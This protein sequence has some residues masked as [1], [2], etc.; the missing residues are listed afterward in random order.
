[1]SPKRLHVQ[2]QSAAAYHA[3]DA[4][5]TQTCPP[6]QAMLPIPRLCRSWCRRAARPRASA[7]TP[8]SA[9][10]AWAHAAP[11]SAGISQLAARAG[12]L[13]LP[14]AVR[15]M[16]APANRHRTADSPSLCP[17]PVQ[18]PRTAAPP[19]AC[20]APASG[21]RLARPPP[22][23]R[24]SRRPLPRLPSIRWRC[25]A[26]ALWATASAQTPPSAAPCGERLNDDSAVFFV[27]AA[28]WRPQGPVSSR[29]LLRRAG[30]LASW[31]HCLAQGSVGSGLLLRHCWSTCPMGPLFPKPTS[32]V[33]C[34]PLC[35]GFCGTGYAWC[36]SDK[37]YCMGGPCKD[38]SDR[39]IAQVGVQGGRGERQ[40]RQRA[41]K[42]WQSVP[43]TP[44]LPALLA[45]AG[46]E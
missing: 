42:T 30:Q 39:P 10:T 46:R 9:A 5:F 6:V 1:M 40:A 37:N 8:C 15:C 35:R 11:V 31:A 27:K 28:C 4:N 38:Y 2:P 25:A 23:R 17:C 18:P 41:A 20:R 33:S 45:Q 7:P 34:L 29:L 24:P 3:V 19:S 32:S 16:S 22:L 44:P 43:V 21:R 12:L 14:L 36:S 26:K 13:E